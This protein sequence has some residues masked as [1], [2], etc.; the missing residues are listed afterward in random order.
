MAAAAFQQLAV[1]AAPAHAAR[2]SASAAILPATSRAAVLPV[3]PAVAPHRASPAASERLLSSVL[4]A[5]APRPSAA[6]AF[7]GLRASAS[8]S[9]PAARS[10]AAP[11]TTVS[12]SPLL[13]AD[14]ANSD[15]ACHSSYLGTSLAVASAAHSN[16]TAPLALTTATARAT[17]P[18]IAVSS[19]TVTQADTLSFH[20]G[21][22]RTSGAAPSS[23]RGT[24]HGSFV[25][26]VTAAALS[27]F[28][29]WS[30]AAVSVAAPF[31]SADPSSR[32][33]LPSRRLSGS[34]SLV[35]SVSSMVGSAA[36]TASFNNAEPIHRHG[37]PAWSVPRLPPAAPRPCSAAERVAQFDFDDD[38]ATP[39]SAT[40]P[41]HFTP[42][43]TL[44]SATDAA[45]G[46]HFDQRANDQ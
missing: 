23:V 42:S 3:A 12:S 37:L 29:S 32:L 36:A 7:T 30:A 26:P 20:G 15:A 34:A 6:P 5:T 27:T 8:S 19:T 45:V 22:D 18:S 14:A 35:D 1:V 39:S 46:A 44:H 43:L 28:P 17:A 9:V 24:L 11:A 4:F 41:S 38:G 25:A 40:M 31:T 16:R 33:L 21:R 10:N 2:A 13:S